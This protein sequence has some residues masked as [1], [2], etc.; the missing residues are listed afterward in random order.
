VHQL[1]L[2]K[3]GALAS[4]GLDAFVGFSESPAHDFIGVSWGIEKLRYWGI[5]AANAQGAEL[6]TRPSNQG[7]H[8]I[9]LTQGWWQSSLLAM[10]ADIYGHTDRERL[11]L[12]ANFAAEDL[13]EW[14]A[15]LSFLLR[16]FIF[17]HEMA[18]YELKH[19]DIH[20]ARWLAG[21]QAS[22]RDCH[23]MEWEADQFAWDQIRRWTS[24]ETG[25]RVVSVLFALFA[26]RPDLLRH[27]PQCPDGRSHPHPLSRFF[28]LVQKI[29]GDN[30]QKHTRYVWFA[31][32]FLCY[33]LEDL[34]AQFPVILSSEIFGTLVHK[35]GAPS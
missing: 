28:W 26:M 30:P 20:R 8:G 24:E 34:G 16:G 32:S 27:Y 2:E 17:Y 35:S 22:A 33:V 3:V 11:A 19:A 15:T 29:G 10:S 31:I 5:V 14:D 6:F 23:L 7:P 21:Q 4:L 13:G 18:H 25:L 9:N 12:I 1:P